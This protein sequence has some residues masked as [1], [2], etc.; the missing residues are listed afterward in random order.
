MCQSKER[1]AEFHASIR[2]RQSIFDNT[3]RRSKQYQKLLPANPIAPKP[4]TK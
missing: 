2:E 1:I 3:G 4:I